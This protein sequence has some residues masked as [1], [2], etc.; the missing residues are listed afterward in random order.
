[1]EP[2]L[3]NHQYNRVAQ[4]AQLLLSALQT[5][6]DGKVVEAARHS[7]LTKAIEACP[8]L[9]GEELRLVSRFA[10]LRSTE[11]FQSYLGELAGY[12]VSFPEMTEKTLKGLFPKVKKLRM[13]DLE[14][15]RGRSLTYLGWTDPGTNRMFLVYPLR[16]PSGDHTAVKLA[17]IEGRFVPAQRKGV[18]AFCSRMGETALF[19]AES[20]AKFSHLPDYYKAV[21]QYICLDSAACNARITD[22]EGL[23]QF[24]QAVSK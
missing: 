23:E 6:N 20:K 21:G 10:E 15:L 5:S 22:P 11:E 16:A 18:C 17:A 13:P 7:T 3:L 19:T 9:A 24:F 2:F 4:Q 1:M 8:G 12:A 14:Q